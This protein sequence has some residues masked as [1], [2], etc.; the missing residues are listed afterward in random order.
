VDASSKPIHSMAAERIA[1][2][3][4]RLKAAREIH[5]A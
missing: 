5:P 3:L 1:A 4:T 2:A